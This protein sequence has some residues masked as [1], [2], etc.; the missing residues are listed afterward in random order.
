MIDI[1]DGRAIDSHVLS[2]H[3][4]SKIRRH[5]AAMHVVPKSYFYRPLNAQDK[6]CN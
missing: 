1:I 3:R 5:A 4:E 6:G 2:A